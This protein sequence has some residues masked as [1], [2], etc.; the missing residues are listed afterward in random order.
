MVVNSVFGHASDSV[1]DCTQR[2]G[3]EQCVRPY[4]LPCVQPSVR[5]YSKLPPIVI[6]SMERH[7]NTAFPLHHF[8]SRLSHLR[9]LAQ[10]HMTTV[11]TGTSNATSDASST[12][13]TSATTP[14]TSTRHPLWPRRCSCLTTK[15]T[16]TG[17]TTRSTQSVGSQ[18]EVC[19]TTTS[20]ITAAHGSQSH[21][22]PSWDHQLLPSRLVVVLLCSFFYPPPPPH[23]HTHT[24]ARAFTHPPT[25]THTDC[26]YSHS[27][28][29]H[30]C[31]T[32]S[33]YPHIH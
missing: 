5:P 33:P 20:R 30:H 2:R 4:A 23:T 31:A 7:S 32:S 6:N 19:P 9:S 12:T 28:H 17:R 13:P 21:T 26:T 16:T 25:S 1:S 18:K 27:G 8:S 29:V 22:G 10:T 15:R 11:I 3:C 24:H 14:V